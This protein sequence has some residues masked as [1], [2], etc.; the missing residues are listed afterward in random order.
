MIFAEKMK[1]FSRME[2][3]CIFPCDTKNSG[4]RV[5][6]VASALHLIDFEISLIFQSWGYGIINVIANC[7]IRQ[8]FDW[9]LKIIASIHMNTAKP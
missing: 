6:N 5:Y 7:S 4:R 2:I 9:L 3:L 1:I 8:R